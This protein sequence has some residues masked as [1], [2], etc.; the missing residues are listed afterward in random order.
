MMKSVVQECAPSVEDYLKDLASK[1]SYLVDYMDA[2]G[3]LDDHCFTFPDGDRWD[4][5]ES[6]DL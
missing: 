3:L 6:H 5:G 4:A 1:V 2:L